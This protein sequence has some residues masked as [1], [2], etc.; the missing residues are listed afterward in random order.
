M[1][2]FRSETRPRDVN[3]RISDPTERVIFAV[4]AWFARLGVSSTELE[5]IGVGSN[6]EMVERIRSMR[7]GMPGG[8]H[9]DEVRRSLEDL[10]EITMRLS[11]DD[12]VALRFAREVSHAVPE[13]RMR[14]LVD[15]NWWSEFRGM[16]SPTPSIAVLAAHALESELGLFDPAGEADAPRPD[17]ATHDE[18]LARHKLAG[19]LLEMATASTRRS[20]DAQWTLAH[21]APYLI[22]E[23]ERFVASSPRW[24]PTCQFLDRALV[25]HYRGAPQPHPH[26]ARAASRIVTRRVGDSWLLLERI[27]Q[28]PPRPASAL[29]LARRVGRTVDRF[30]VRRDVTRLF[31]DAVSD[32]RLPVRVR[33]SA[34]WIA[35]ENSQ[36]LPEARNTEPAVIALM[37]ELATDTDFADVVE[38]LRS[39][40]GGFTE[41]ARDGTLVDFS[42]VEHDAEGALEWPCSAAVQR[43]L[44]RHIL[45]SPSSE[46]SLFM[47]PWD[48]LPRNLVGAARRMLL[49]MMIH[50]DLVRLKAAGDTLAAGGVAV[51]GAVCRTLSL[52]LDDPEAR[53]LPDHMVEIAVNTM[54]Q[55]RGHASPLA[56]LVRIVESDRSADCR[57]AAIAALGDVLDHLRRND[58]EKSRR[59]LGRAV[60]TLEVALHSPEV[61]VVNAAIVALHGLPVCPVSTTLR[62]LAR[63]HPNQ[64]TR[65]MALWRLELPTESPATRRV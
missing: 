2:R 22:D 21:L 19:I 48:R 65:D 5:L 44:S 60:N 1:A 28:R 62:A 58:P 51:A 57:A 17:D 30:E 3:V 41:W 46:G 29:R 15:E 45:P 53:L 6:R 11:P 50:P 63:E 31:L 16:P 37:D 7:F 40:D 26:V 23:I 34:L 47:S 27:N 20:E 56:T 10:R 38:T 55:V 25:L 8:E 59:G 18:W 42:S 13:P 4:H 64:L 32:V 35:A 61:A 54:S 24:V 43:I 14:E 36:A 12:T 52:M 49:E 9:T 33:R 39:F